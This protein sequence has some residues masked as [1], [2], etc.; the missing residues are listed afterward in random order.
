MLELGSKFRA[1]SCR[2]WCQDE[3]TAKTKPVNHKEALAGVPGEQFP[4]FF[5]GSYQKRCLL[6]LCPSRCAVMRSDPSVATMSEADLYVLPPQ[7]VH[8][9]RTSEIQSQVW[10]ASRT[11]TSNCASS[12][13][14]LL[15][16]RYISQIIFLSQF[17]LGFLRHGSQKIPN[18]GG[19]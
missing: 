6:F 11:F 14:N 16:C 10:T 7:R 12:Q 15:F 4:L 1:L 8:G 18:S 3:D 19:N 17:G 5:I 9:H 13:Q 2:L